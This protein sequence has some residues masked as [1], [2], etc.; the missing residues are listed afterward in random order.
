MNVRNCRKCGRVYNHVVGPTICPAC[1]EQ[2]DKK[3]GE[4]KE[5]VREHRGAT[6][7]EVSEK[8]EVEVQ[9]I[10]QWLR[11]E[12][13]E[14]M[15]GSGIVLQCESCG[16]VIYSGRFCQ[17]C[18]NGLARGLNKSIAPAPKAAPEPVKQTRDKDKMRFL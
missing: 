2:M 12:R 13:L 8:C 3:F 18:K 15:E 6:I 9:Q 11:E 4:V 10:H 16:A 14:L 5:Y 17:G 7:N 1:R